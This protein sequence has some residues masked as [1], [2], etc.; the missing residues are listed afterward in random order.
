MTIL[1]KFI[2]R[3]G[4][5]LED[6]I[7]WIRDVSAALTHGVSL[8]DNM[9]GELV[10]FRWNSDAPPTVLLKSTSKPIGLLVISASEPGGAAVAS[11]MAIAWQWAPSS[12][13][14]KVQI[15][16]IDILAASTDYDVTAWAVGG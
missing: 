6:A 12:T 1:Q 11:G 14:G 13:Q 2:P 15:T 5:K 16:T 8:A 9:A 10:T 3:T 4:A 7:G